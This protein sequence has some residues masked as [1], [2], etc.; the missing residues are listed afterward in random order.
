MLALVYHGPGDERLV[1]EE[2]SAPTLLFP[3]DAI[4]RT[5]MVAICSADLAAVRG[6]LSVVPGTVLGHEAVGIVEEVGPAVRRVQ[7]GQRVVVSAVSA[8]GQCEPCRREM[9]GQCRSGGGRL[10]GRVIHGVHAEFARV[11]F[12]D[13]G[14][15]PLPDHVDDVDA[16]FLSE[17]L[18]TAYECALAR[19]RLQPGDDV[20]IVGAGPVGLATLLLARLQGAHRVIVVDVDDARLNLA[21]HLGA[22]HVL[23]P[24]RQDI[25]RAAAGV[26][27]DGV[28]LAVEAVGSVEA[29]ELCVGLVRPGGR[30]AA[31]GSYSRAVRL[32]LE[33]LWRRD[34]TIVT[35]TMDGY[36][37]PQLLRLIETRRL[38]PRPL[39]SHIVDFPQL[40]EAYRLAA[41]AR[42]S[43]VCKALARS[44]SCY[45][46]GPDPWPPVPWW[47]G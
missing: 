11:P 40:A 24:R 5:T 34:V 30:V 36:S 47:G 41:D 29:F 9:Y 12:A 3:T 46:L 19:G 38:R 37:M 28:D 17:V 2:V 39:A 42:S 32:G 4:V 16:V 25:G 43:G 8:C 10:L 15:H 45:C 1:M 35:H 33:R 13:M 44:I 27:G 18:P 26:T 31:I 21:L 14:L 7:P 22:D 6:D 23:N 20:L